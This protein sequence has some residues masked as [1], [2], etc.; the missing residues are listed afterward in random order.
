MQQGSV[1]GHVLCVFF[2]GSLFFHWPHRDSC[3]ANVFKFSLHAH[4]LMEPQRRLWLHSPA[5]PC[6]PA[7][8]S[9][10]V[11]SWGQQVE[12]K[13]LAQPC[14]RAP[15]PFFS[16]PALA[17]EPFFS[18]PALAPEPFFSRRR[19]PEARAAG[20]PFQAVRYCFCSPSGA[21]FLKRF[22]GYVFHK[23]VPSGPLR[24]PGSIFFITSLVLG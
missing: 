8:P 22:P 16:S 5:Q 21:R 3:D 24:T 4:R 17:P 9:L 2:S 12:G 19:A 10:R 14:Q 23:T 20:P 11:A 7:A 15:E 1:W 13:W 18:P 6:Q